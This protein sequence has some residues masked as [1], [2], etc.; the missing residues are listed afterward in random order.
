MI[1]LLCMALLMGLLISSAFA[2]TGEEFIEF[3]TPV[4]GTL[5]ANEV[6]T[7]RFVALAG[8]ML[9][10]SFAVLLGLALLN[11]RSTRVFG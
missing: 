7:W 3:Y 2:Q 8:S 9:L 10:F 6:Q 11:R 5:R 4:I 1:R